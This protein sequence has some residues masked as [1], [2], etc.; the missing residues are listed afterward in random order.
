METEELRQFLGRIT[1]T[2][3]TY[4]TTLLVLSKGMAVVPVV[5]TVMTAA[6]VT[7]D[8]FMA[9]YGCGADFRG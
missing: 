1:T 5:A 7:T 9:G 8:N 3:G 6:S 2:T 4:V